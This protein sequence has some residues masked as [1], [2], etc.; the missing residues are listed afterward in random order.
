MPKV[1]SNRLTRWSILLQ[2]YN[3]T[4]QHKPGREITHADALTRLQLLNDK[5]EQE[6]LI[7]N[8]FAENIS[9]DWNVTLSE[10]TKHDN[11][12]QSIMK[13]L[14][15]D[16]WRNLTTQEKRFF[17]LREQLSIQGDLLYLEDKCYIP[18]LLRRDV[19]NE[20]HKLHS[21]IHSTINQI[22]LNSWWPTLIS[23]IRRWIRDCPTCSQ[24][25]PISNNCLLYT[26]PSPRDLS[27]S[28]MPSS[29]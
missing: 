13:R 10:A 9:D 12:A 15:S 3:F 27:T 7:I 5:S 23:D 19:Y 17:R 22:K 26:S 14:R 20:S 25:R 6:D 18:P 4:I 16:N 21:G 24:L 1:D 2:R 11:L 8:N 28:R 29:A